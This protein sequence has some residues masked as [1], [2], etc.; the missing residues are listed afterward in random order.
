MYWFELTSGRTFGIMAERRGVVTMTNEEKILEMLT[1]M[2]AEIKEVKGEIK[3]IRTEMEETKAEL[4]E[5]HEKVDVLAE[6]QEELRTS[7]NAI[8]DWTDTVST[9]VPIVP[10]IS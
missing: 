1:G 3:E 5:V 9:V 4:K 6:S 2:Q 8:L 7:V 10:K